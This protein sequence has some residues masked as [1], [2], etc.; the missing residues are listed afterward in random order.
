MSFLVVCTH[1]MLLEVILLKIHLFNIAAYFEKTHYVFEH[2]IS[3]H[4]QWRG[5]TVTTDLNQ[6]SVR[7]TV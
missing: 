4:K 6:V 7:H 2:C 5:G 1:V 3:E